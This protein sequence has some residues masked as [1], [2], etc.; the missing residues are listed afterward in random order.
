MSTPAWTSASPELI[1]PEATVPLDPDELVRRFRK[2]VRR[3]VA[4]QLSHGHPVYSGGAGADAGKLFM[5]MPDGRL[6]E[7]RADPDG[8]R[9]V[10]HELPE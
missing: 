6:L 2:G 9:T 1:L 7:Y 10:L 5:R 3:A 4:L 8:T